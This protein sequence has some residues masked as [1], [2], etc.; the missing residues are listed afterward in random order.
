[1]R[2]KTVVSRNERNLKVYIF[3]G[4]GY[5]SPLYRLLICLRTNRDA[6]PLLVRFGDLSHFV[7][8]SG[9]VC[10]EIEEE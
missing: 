8:A 1:M 5:L 7:D 3:I 10:E 6:L 4:I 2:N 9:R